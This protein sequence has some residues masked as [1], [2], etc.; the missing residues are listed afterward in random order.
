M[1]IGMQRAVPRLPV[2]G[3]RDY[4]LGLASTHGVAYVETPTDILA[5]AITRLADDDVHLDEIECLLIALERAGVVASDSVVPL[6][7]NYLRE[8]LNVRSV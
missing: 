2:S 8:K 3:L 1:P 7:I 5:D 6:H 4:I